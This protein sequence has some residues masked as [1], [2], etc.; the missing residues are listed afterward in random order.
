MRAVDGRKETVA[1]SYTDSHCPVGCG[2]TDLKEM[3]NLA[4]D[5]HASQHTCMESV[6]AW[7]GRGRRLAGLL[8]RSGR[9]D[10]GSDMAHFM[11]VSTLRLLFIRCSTPL[12]P[13]LVCLNVLLE[14]GI[15]GI[16]LWVIFFI[17]VTLCP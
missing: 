11:L 16:G 6:R 4:A 14:A 13:F 10:V 5:G 3:G 15:T 9:W 7:R 17:A 2:S 8:A 12:L 1:G